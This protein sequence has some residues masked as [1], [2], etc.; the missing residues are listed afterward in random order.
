MQTSLTEGGPSFSKIVFGV[1]KW[2]LWGHQLD[3]QKMLRL[4]EESIDYGVTTF[5]H[6][7]IYGNYTTEAEF[8]AALA[9]NPGLRE[10][11]QLVTKCGIKMK[12]PQRPAHRF[13]SYDTST[14]HIR[15]SVD[16][17]LRNL[18]TDYI[19]LLLI[20]RPSPLMDVD[21]IASEFEYLRSE[22]KVLHFGVSNFTPSQFKMLNSRIPLVT[23]QVEASLLHLDPFFD[24]TFDQAQELKLKPMAWSPLGGGGIF[25]TAPDEQS[26]RII[27]T[28]NS[29]I[30]ERAQNIGVDQ[31]LLAWLMRHPAGIMPVVGTARIERLKAAADAVNIMLSQEEWFELLEAARGEEVA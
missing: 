24:G 31:L 13:K 5:D 10:K 23:N 6:A 26:I 18:K 4:I 15:A 9:L 12:V 7:D 19:D 27:K 16:Q 17:S 21:L 20:H 2:G 1:M 28:A 8:G 11:M 3:S 30:E 25:S 14:Q 29:I 22:G